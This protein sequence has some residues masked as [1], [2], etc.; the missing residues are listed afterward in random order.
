MS[1]DDRTSAAPVLVQLESPFTAKTPQA[2]QLNQLYAR[3]A[4]RDSLL[5]SEA[6]MASHMLYAQKFVLDDR[7][8]AERVMGMEA[9]FA[10]LRHVERVVVYQDRGISPGMEAGI[11]RAQALGLPVEYRSIEKWS[12]K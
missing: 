6:P 7:I 5:R 4:M 2:Q 11:A 1:G 9:G 8:A 3:E 10:W 12:R